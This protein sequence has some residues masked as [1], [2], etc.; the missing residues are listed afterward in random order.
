M[1]IYE[2]VGIA[3]VVA[4]GAVSVTMCIVAC[5]ALVRTLF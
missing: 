3:V 4:L 5:V 1:T 2:K